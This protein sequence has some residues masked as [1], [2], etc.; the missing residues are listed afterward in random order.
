MRK[1]QTFAQWMAGARTGPAN[2]HPCQLGRE[3]YD[4]A[5]VDFLHR[6][7]W[8]IPTWAD[9][10]KLAAESE[11]AA[12]V[13]HNRYYLNY[14]TIVIPCH[15]VIGSDGSLRGYAGGVERKR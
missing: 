11:Y 5:I 9:Q 13:I 4:P 1:R 6:L 12:W 10:T 7:L 14:F 8:S 2:V 3:R 15:R